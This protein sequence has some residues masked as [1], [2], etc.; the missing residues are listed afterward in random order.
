MPHWKRFALLI[1]FNIISLDQELFPLVPVPCVID[2][3][4]LDDLRLI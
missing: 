2:E 3:P 1:E 4:C